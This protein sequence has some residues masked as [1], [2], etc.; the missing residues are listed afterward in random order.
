[1]SMDHSIPGPSLGIAGTS[2][3]TVITIIQ[4]GQLK[5]SDRAFVLYFDT[6]NTTIITSIILEYGH[7]ISV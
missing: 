1:M 6:I 7:M 3:E 5:G 2:E 4:W